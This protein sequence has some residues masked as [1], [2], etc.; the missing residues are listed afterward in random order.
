VAMADLWNNGSLDVIVA[1]QNNI[2]ILYK[3]IITNH[4]HWIEFDLHGTLSNADAVGA[5]V[6]VEWNGRKQIQVVT[7][8]MGF[9]SQNQHRLHFGIGKSTRIDRV[10]IYWPSGEFTTIANPQ[11]DKLHI[12]IES[13]V[14]N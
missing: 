14:K 5:K 3:N 9:S 2:P 4:N 8:G 12:I 11:I 1:N 6:V 10:L 7:G 13:K